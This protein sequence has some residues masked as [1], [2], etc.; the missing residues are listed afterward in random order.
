MESE[1]P[2]PK[3]KIVVGC[4]GWNYDDWTTRSPDSPVFYPRGTRSG[5]MLGFY[6]KAFGTTEIDSTF[7]AIPPAS[8][9]ENWYRKTSDDFTFSPKMPQEI[10]HEMRL[11]EDAFPILD[12]FCERIHGLGRKLAVCLI[13]LPPQFEANRPNAI[14]LRQ[15][16][17]RLPRD[18][19]FAVEFR[20]REW[21]VDWT[22]DELARNGA[23]PALVEGK[24]IPRETIFAAALRIRGEFSYV[25]FMG[26]RD[27]TSFDRICRSRDDQLPEWA[28]AIES[29]ETPETFIYFSNL[30]EGHA[31]ESARKLS[32]LL[33]LP[34]VDPKS[35]DDQRALF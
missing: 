32:V 18:I 3:P 10:T 1:I 12:G 6:S 16:L 11:S 8:N 20:R 35:L 23:T 17:E 5:E 7:Y 29:L 2:N 15:F 14:R 26:E 9:I 19:R 4:Q 25:R 33:G 30:Y 24:W 21:F 28:R 31:P 34:T 27:L 13:Q 22:Y